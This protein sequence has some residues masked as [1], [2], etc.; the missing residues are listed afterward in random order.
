VVIVRK[1]KEIKHK[2]FQRLKLNSSL[3]TAQDLLHHIYW[4]GGITGSLKAKKS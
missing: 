1:T 2:M 3:L 4:G